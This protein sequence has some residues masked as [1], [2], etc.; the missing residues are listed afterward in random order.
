MDWVPPDGLDMES[1]PVGAIVQAGVEPPSSAQPPIGSP[2]PAALTSVELWTVERYGGLTPL[3]ADPL[4]EYVMSPAMANAR[5]NR[6]LDPIETL[7][8][9]LVL[10]PTRLLDMKPNT[11][12]ITGVAVG[13]VGVSYDDLNYVFARSRG[14]DMKSMRAAH[15]L[16]YRDQH[17]ALEAGDEVELPLIHMHCKPV[18]RFLVNVSVHA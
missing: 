11:V 2:P 5:G 3:R 17:R 4:P 8:L 13:G 18:E 1:P 15:I 14:G 9:L 16:A 10:K 12:G 6:A 7:A